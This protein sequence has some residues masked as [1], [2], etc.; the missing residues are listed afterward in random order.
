M[1]C[2]ECGLSFTVLPALKRHLF[3]VHKIRDLAK[4]RAD[5]GINLAVIESNAIGM[6]SLSFQSSLNGSP[7]KSQIPNG[8]KPPSLH[9]VKKRP[10]PV[11]VAPREKTSPDQ[12]GGDPLVTLECNVCYKSFD[13][14]NKLRKHMRAHGMAFIRSR[15]TDLRNEQH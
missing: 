7:C 10:Q 3:M 2:V 4:Y 11:K 14:S 15:R 12:D 1:Q 13:D 6:S 8:I 5:T 9:P